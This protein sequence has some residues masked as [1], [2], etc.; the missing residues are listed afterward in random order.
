[1]NPYLEMFT[2]SWIMM[3]FI[4]V[5]GVAVIAGVLLRGIRQQRF[6][7]SL[8]AAFVILL[9]LVF[10]SGLSPF[11]WRI[12]PTISQPKPQPRFV[13][14]ERAAAI[15]DATGEPQF[16]PEGPALQIPQ[17]AEFEEQGA[18]REMSQTALLSSEQWLL[19][20]WLAGAVASLVPAVLSLFAA[21]RLPQGQAPAEIRDR[22]KKLAGVRSAKVPVHVSSKVAG[23]GVSGLFRPVVVL[24]SSAAEWSEER[25]ECVLRHEF[26]HLSRHDLALRW[27]GRIARALLWFHPAAWWGQHRLEL[28]QELAADEAVVAEGVST[29]A[30]AEHLLAMAAQAR[31]FPGIA[32]ARQS[33]VG[34]RIRLLLSKRGP[35]G[36]MRKNLERFA[37]IAGGAGVTAISL[38]GFS[39]PG[40]ASAGELP[41]IKISDKGF[42]PPIVDRNG[43]L[44]ATSDP[45]RM[46]EELRTHPP[47]RWYPEGAMLGHF[48]GHIFR[49]KKGEIRIP[50][51]MGLESDGSLRADKPLRTSIDLRIQRL[52]WGAL[53]KRKLPGSV[54]VMDPRNGEVLA[55]ASWPSYDPNALVRGT[56][57]EDFDILL[58]DPRKL[59]LNRAVLPEAPGSVAM[60]L[61]ALAAAK[62][63]KI[64]R[65][66]HCGPSV[67][68]G[69]IKLNDWDQNRNED[70]GLVGAM[71]TGCN[72]YFAPLATELGPEAMKQIGADFGFDRKTSP[73][74]PGRPN[75]Y[76][77][78]PV[79]AYPE[80]KSFDLALTSIGQGRTRFSVMDTA[81][82]Y[83]AIAGGQIRPPVFTAGGPAAGA[84]SLEKLGIDPREVGVIRESLVASA[85]RSVKAIRDGGLNGV[86]A[87]K[88][89]TAQGE[90]VEGRQFHTMSFAGFA[91][92]S[93]PK[94]VVSVRF[95]AGPKEEPTQSGALV[96][97]PVAADLIKRLLNHEF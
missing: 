77:F 74:W 64:D 7:S 38:L 9:P 79:N 47:V 5:V 46:P 34:G 57:P 17:V 56:S 30:Y 36:R 50:E 87:G 32:M 80:Y 71:R 31:C 22:W 68:F 52:V 94:Y 48:T 13:V 3:G 78:E 96:A 10:F 88:A 15:I 49:D 25:L 65:V 11:S 26:Q 27:L 2:A 60:V 66:I 97:G 59:L 40:P 44:I 76:G 20:L 84:V 85:E 91:P 37:A 43:L 51:G 42:R 12:L 90:V 33:Q 24:P 62:A 6:A 83:S 8:W 29:A 89:A 35:I 19:L 70:L 63:D 18:S 95:T 92:A 39:S 53:E 72:T 75:W 67:T 28:A 93:Q 82:I 1:M 58:N 54:V 55:M 21:R 23:P 45:L 73:P 16:S 69:N 61:T 81:R 86:I 4:K 14:A 41:E